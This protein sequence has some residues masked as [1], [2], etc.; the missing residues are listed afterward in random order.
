[1]MNGWMDEWWNDGWTGGRMDGHTS[2]KQIDRYI[3]G[4]WMDVVI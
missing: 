2:N 4:S 3:N 1:M